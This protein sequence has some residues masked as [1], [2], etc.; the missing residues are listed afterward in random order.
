MS[1]QY[2]ITPRGT[3]CKAVVK[4]FA[5]LSCLEQSFIRLAQHWTKVIHTIDN[6]KVTLRDA[7]NAVGKD[8]AQVAGEGF[9]KWDADGLVSVSS[10]PSGRFAEEDK[11]LRF[12][13]K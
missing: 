6:S 8:I 7:I 4:I 5:L 3:I 12:G 2:K 1:H 9:L 13:M 10:V 11:S